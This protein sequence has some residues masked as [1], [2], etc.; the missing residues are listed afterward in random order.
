MKKEIITTHI[1]T[2][3][4]GYLSVSK[5]DILLVGMDPAEI[6]GYSGMDFNRV[7]LEEDSDATL[8]MNKAEEKG[9]RVI[10]KGGYNLSF[11]NHHNYNSRLFNLK[12]ELGQKFM[13]HNDE[14]LEFVSISPKLIVTDPYGKRYKLPTSNPFKYIKDSI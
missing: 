11:S 13:G 5:K 4:H 6:S 12:K 14:V 2:G 10:V 8:F 7:Y 1:D 3:G 9:I